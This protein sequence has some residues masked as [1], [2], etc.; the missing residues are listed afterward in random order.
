[1]FL[2]SL[3]YSLNSL[4]VFLFKREIVD[5][6]ENVWD[7]LYSKSNSNV[8]ADLTENQRG[9]RPAGLRPVTQRPVGHMWRLHPQAERQ[10][11]R[12]F[13]PLPGQ[14][15]HLWYWNQP[16]RAPP[17]FVCSSFSETHC[18]IGAGAV[19][20]WSRW[21]LLSFFNLDILVCVFLHPPFAAFM[22]LSS[23]ST[24]AAQCPFRNS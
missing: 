16:L 5:F 2:S 19:V 11:A 21:H 6:D 14:H 20:L 15:V 9:R 1:M 12:G 3:I 22:L 4:F 23:E 10:Q 18:R 24:K 8:N 7:R 13:G 17:R